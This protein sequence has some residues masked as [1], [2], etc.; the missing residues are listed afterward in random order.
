ME[1]EAR[2]R[3]SQLNR[4]F[5]ERL[6]VLRTQAKIT[7]PGFAKWF[8]VSRTQVK[9]YEAGRVGMSLAF[10]FSISEEF[11]LPLDFFLEGLNPLAYTDPPDRDI[12]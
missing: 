10:V 2:D 11:D 3:Q 12:F 8:G 9:N 7:C 1:H 5:G 4:H 6:K